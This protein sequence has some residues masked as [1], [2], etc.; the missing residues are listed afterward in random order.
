M[1]FDLKWFK[2]NLSCK[3]KEY[4]ITYNFFAN[5][6][7]GDIERVEFE[8]NGKGG[9]IDFWSSGWLGIH[10][11]SYITNQQ[12][13]NILLEPDEQSQKNKAF[14]DLIKILNY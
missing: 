10:V 11:Y 7:L 6:D 14:D 13:M 5:G 1:D 2:E 12:L 8:G 4:Q 3:F 9:S